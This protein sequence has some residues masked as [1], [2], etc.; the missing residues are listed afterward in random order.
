MYVEYIISLE[1]DGYIDIR[2]YIFTQKLD[3]TPEFF[4]HKESW[5]S[6]DWL[7]NSSRLHSSWIRYFYFVLPSTYFLRLAQKRSKI[8]SCTASR[9]ILAP[10][11]ESTS[12]EI[13]FS[14]KN[15]KSNSYEVARKTKYGVLSKCEQ[16]ETV[17][18][19]PG[20]RRKRKLAEEL[21]SDT[22]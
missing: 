5:P 18:D 11:M 14:T 3:I 15:K 1:T 9:G 22:F 21:E 2:S 17:D 6:Y 7:L 4:L 16:T 20:R 10:F 12:W 13:I 8:G 19:H